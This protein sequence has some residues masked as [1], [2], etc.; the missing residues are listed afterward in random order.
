MT[1]FRRAAMWSLCAAAALSCGRAEPAAPPLDPALI[2]V[3]AAQQAVLTG[4]VGHGKWES[5]ASYVLVEA[6]SRAD[7]DA[8]VTLGGELTDAAGQPIGGLRRESLRIP[9]GGSRLFALVDQEQ[10]ARPA[11]RGARI[12]V[13]GAVAVDTPPPVVVTEGH[14]YRDGD[15]VDLN[16]K[17]VNTADGR[18]TAVVFFAFF[19]QDGAPLKRVSTVFQLAPR[20]SRG[21]HWVGPDGSASGSMFIGEVAY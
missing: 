21:A 8:L 13:A 14:V 20:A 12:E 7:R 17:V 19:D 10:A 6:R 18:A 4:P 1:V 2:E 15:R 11:A 9:A 3:V 16:G 5:T